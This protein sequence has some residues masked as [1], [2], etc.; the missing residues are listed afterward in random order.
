MSYSI[1]DPVTYLVTVTL[2]VIIIGAIVG[3]SLTQ[4]PRSRYGKQPNIAVSNAVIGASFGVFVG[5]VVAVLSANW[6]NVVTGFFA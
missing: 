6:L 1:H 5:M 4:K 3:V 2:A